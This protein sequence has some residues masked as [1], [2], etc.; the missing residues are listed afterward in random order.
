M[1]KPA[2]NQLAQLTIVSELVTD[3]IEIKGILLKAVGEVV[4]VV[5]PS[6]LGLVGDVVVVVG[7]LLDV[8]LSLVGDIVEG[9]YSVVE[10]LLGRKSP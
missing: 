2:T 1:I 3:L 7:E 10:T 4:A 5:L 8:V 9:L 6:V